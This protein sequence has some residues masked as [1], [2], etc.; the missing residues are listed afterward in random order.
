M[1]TMAPRAVGRL[2]LVGAMGIKPERGEIAD[3]ALL[4]YIDYA[5]LG[6]A[7]Q[8]AFDRLFGADPPTS[9]LEQ[10]DLNREM[11]CRC[12]SPTRACGSRACS[13][14]RRSSGQPGSATPTSRSARR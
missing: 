4:S 12:R 5:R 1:V 2:V 11:T 3:Q 6:F 14:R 13:A 7:D 9:L 8:G 10:W